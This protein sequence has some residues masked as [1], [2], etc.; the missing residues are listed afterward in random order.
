MAAAAPQTD[1]VA[2]VL[3]AGTGTRLR[4]LTDDRPKCLVEVGGRPLLDRLLDRLAQAGLR[5]ACLATGYRAEALH[6]HFTR[7]P[8]PLELSFT[9][10]PRFATTQNAF[11]LFSVQQAVGD[12]GFVLCDGDVL[13]R[14]GV[15]ERLVASPFDAALLVERREDMGAEEMKARVASDGRVTGLAKTFDPA[16][17]FGESIGVQKLGPATAPK[18]WATLATMMASGGEGEYYEA[19]FQRLIDGGTPFGAVAVSGEEWTE[20]DDL[21]DLERAELRA[22]SGEWDR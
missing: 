14:R 9:P 4:P 13:L 12:A 21:A 1:L 15:L 17:C 18:L 20:I 22:R 6:A 3:V 11:S 10:N 5:R 7:S 8:A 2:V 16:T 19:A